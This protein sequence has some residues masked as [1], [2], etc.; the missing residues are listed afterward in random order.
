M[1]KNVQSATS[2]GELGVVPH[3]TVQGVKTTRQF[4]C[5]HDLV[6]G[7][8]G[9]TGTDSWTMLAPNPAWFLR[10]VMEAT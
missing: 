3:A 6:A 9:G 8:A 1:T 2:A 5:R 4:R 7:V 10:N